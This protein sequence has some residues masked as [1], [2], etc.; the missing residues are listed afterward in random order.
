M[1][2]PRELVAVG[3][4]MG[5]VYRRAKALGLDKPYKFTHSEARKILNFKKPR[6]SA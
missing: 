2:R 3:L 4:S 5:T 6:K 1:I